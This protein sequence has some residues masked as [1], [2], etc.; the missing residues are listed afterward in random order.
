MQSPDSDVPIS[1][2]TPEAVLRDGSAI[3]R[4]RAAILLF[5]W[6]IAIALATTIDRPVAYW[7]QA[8]RPLDKPVAGY[9]SRSGNHPVWAT[10]LVRLPGNYLFVAAVGVALGI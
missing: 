5:L 3:T 7:V 2:A 8:H 4:F 9:V 6:I 1:S 10:K